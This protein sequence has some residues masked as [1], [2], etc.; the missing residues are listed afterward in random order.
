MS[1][2]FLCPDCLTVYDGE[3]LNH[4]FSSGY[5]IP[6]PRSDCE[7]NAFEIDELMI[8]TIQ[9]LISKGYTTDFCCSGHYEKFLS[10]G[11]ICFSEYIEDLPSLPKGFYKEIGNNGQLIIRS[12]RILNRK[13]KSPNDFYDICDEAKEL[14]KWALSLPMYEY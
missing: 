6:C 13:P 3:L 2:K 5:D 4:D 9:T 7:G 8:P 12:N 14:Y 11:Y 10:Y 1:S